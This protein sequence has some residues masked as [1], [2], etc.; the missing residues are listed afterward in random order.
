MRTGVKIHVILTLLCLVTIQHT[1]NAQATIIGNTTSKDGVNIS[2]SVYGQGNITIAFIHG[3]SC[4]SRYWYQ[5]ISYFSKKYQ[6]ITID[7]AGHGNSELSRKDYTMKAF[8]E[9]IAAVFSKVNAKNVILAGHSMGGEITLMA[10]KYMQNRVIGVIG[11]DTLHDLGHH[12]TKEQIDSIYGPI[13]KDFKKN[14]ARFVKVMFPKNA[15]LKLVKAIMQDMSSA[16]RK[17]ALSAM[18]N[19]LKLYGGNLVKNLNIPIH[20]INSDLWPT[21]IKRNKALTK[22]Y[23]LQIMKGYGH[24]I[25]LE[26]PDLFNQLLGQSIKNIL[27]K[28]QLKNKTNEK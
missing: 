15:N 13:A 8:V 6:V 4:D 2:Y 10:A 7:L 27:K 5:Q 25:M 23:E 18:H 12:N 14:T 1:C 22:S 24:F 3:W 20:S 26:A 19:Y 21:N 28:V 16:P 17:V 9:D 11:I